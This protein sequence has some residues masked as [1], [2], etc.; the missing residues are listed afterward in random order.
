MNRNLLKTGT[1][2]LLITIIAL[3]FSCSNPVKEKKRLW[4]RVLEVEAALHTPNQNFPGMKAAEEAIVV[5]REFATKYPQDSMAFFYHVKAADIAFTLQQY[6]VSG[7]IFEEV[8]EKHSQREGFAYVYL[9]LGSLYN[10]KLQDTAKA[11]I[12]FNRILSEYPNNQY[13]ES[14]K[15]GLDHLGMNEQ[16]QLETILQRNKELEAGTA[17]NQ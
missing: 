4:A 1:G 3:L 15:F 7:E 11:R 9:R 2:V 14:A 5:F 6:P 10:D 8:L 17:E 12:F 13:V 16:Q